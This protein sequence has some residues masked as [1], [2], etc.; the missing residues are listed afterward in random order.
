MLIGNTML[1]NMFLA[2][3][4]KFLEDAVHEV[5]ASEKKDREEKLQ[6]KDDARKAMEIEKDREQAFHDKIYSSDAA[7]K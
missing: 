1:L 5:R 6:L 4:L 3:M 2:I 7:K